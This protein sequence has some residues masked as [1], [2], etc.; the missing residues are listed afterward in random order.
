MI[1]LGPPISKS[2]IGKSAFLLAVVASNAVAGL[3]TGTVTFNGNTIQYQAFSGTD[4]TAFTAFLQGAQLVN[5]ETVSGVTP[6]V[7]TAYTGSPTTAANLI[8]PKVALGG[9][10]FSAGGQTPGNPANGGAPSVLL[11]VSSL[12][13]AHSGQN[14]IGPTAQ[15]DPTTPLDFNGFISVDFP[16]ATP[17][18]RFGWWTNPQGGKVNFAP[19]INALDTGGNLVDLSTGITFTA[20][21]GEFV[22]FAFSGSV[23]NEVELFQTGPMTVDDFTYARD[24][25]LPFS[26]TTATTTPEPASW[27]LLALGCSA[28]LVGKLPVSKSARKHPAVS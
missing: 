1:R 7:V 16:L 4:P 23:V 28:I 9:A 22:A 10:F 19:H 5:F 13:G 20:N 26:T 8:D 6:K 12:N 21:P 14:V 27:L 15:G 18:S 25:T 17:I 2:I 11:N 3:V 24:N